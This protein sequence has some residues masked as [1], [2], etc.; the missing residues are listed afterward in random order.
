MIGL[1]GELALTDGCWR[2]IYD[3]G[4]QIGDGIGVMHYLCNM[5]DGSIRKCV[6][7]NLEI[8]RNI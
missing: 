8:H 4:V 6:V 7:E 3:I 1:D 5:E 2:H